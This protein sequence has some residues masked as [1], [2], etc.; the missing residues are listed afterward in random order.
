MAVAKQKE[1]LET[2]DLNTQEGNERSGNTA[3]TNDHDAKGKSKTKRETK[4]LPTCL[5][6]QICNQIKEK[7]KCKKIK[8]V[9]IL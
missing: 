2:E 7:L 3:D 8:L 5:F 9:L 6:H 1:Q 4:Q